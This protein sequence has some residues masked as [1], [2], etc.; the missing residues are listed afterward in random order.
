MTIKNINQ[1]FIEIQ[2]R[3]NDA[4]KTFIKNN[5][6]DIPDEFNRTPLLNSALYGNAELILWLI[7]HGA[8][9]NHKDENGYTALHFSARE[10]NI[11]CTKILIENG[12]DIN[13]QD[14]HGNTA[15]WLCIM[16]WGGGKN[17]KTLE[18][19]IQSNANLELK[20]N[21]GR[22]AMDLIP[23]SLRLEFNI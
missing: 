6:V 12:I 8:N 1:L 4:V 18:L 19:L 15:S 10:K 16:N 22:S 7:E 21:A 11:K 20:N 23:D 9:I 13:A 14:K 17:R 2:N 3:E 5:S